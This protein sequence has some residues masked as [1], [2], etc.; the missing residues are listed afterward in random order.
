LR[1]AQYWVN[2]RSTVSGRRTDSMVH[3]LSYIFK[4]NV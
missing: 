2:S 4:M 3:S 1:A